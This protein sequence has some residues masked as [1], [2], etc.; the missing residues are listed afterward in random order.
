MRTVIPEQT[1]ERGGMEAVHKQLLQCLKNARYWLDHMIENQ[2][3]DDWDVMIAHV[4]GDLG[5]AADH[6]LLFVQKQREKAA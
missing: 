2:G 5:D 1:F 6:R 3:Y 4:L